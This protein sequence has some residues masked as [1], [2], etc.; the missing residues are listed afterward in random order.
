MKLELDQAEL[1]HWTRNLVWGEEIEIVIGIFYDSWCLLQET[2]YSL[3]G[4]NMC[5]YIKCDIPW[6]YNVYV[7]EWLDLMAKL[8]DFIFE[9]W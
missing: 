3:S 8:I 9:N 7:S 4:S 2:Y 6:K 1:W 5:F